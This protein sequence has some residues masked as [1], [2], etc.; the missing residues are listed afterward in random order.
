MKELI[1]KITRSEL[2]K[3]LEITKELIKIHEDFKILFLEKGILIYTILGEDS[4]KINALKVFN[5]KWGIMFSEFPKTL[6]LNITFQEGKKFYDKMSFLLDTKDEDDIYI[7][8]NYNKEF[9]AYSFGG[10]NSDL[11]VR[12]ICQP[13]NN[14]KDLTFDIL[15]EKLNS[16][17]AEWNFDITNEQLSKII[18]LSKTEDSKLLSIRI[19]DNN[20]IFS[21]TQW[22]IKVAKIDKNLKGNWFIKKEYLKYIINDPSKDILTFSIFPSY[23]VINETKS[24]FLFSMDL[25]D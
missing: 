9:Y 2:S 10:K 6:F 5:F 11:E 13:N 8:I 7:T 23:I 12:A 4:G 20:I 19:D 16:D 21:D 1:F 22:D 18:K 24:H 25:M 17:Y 15:K 14:V 3:F